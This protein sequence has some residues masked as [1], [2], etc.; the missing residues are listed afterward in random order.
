ME[1]EQ[2][3]YRALTAISDVAN[4]SRQS[5]LFFEN[6]KRVNAYIHSLSDE[7]GCDLLFNNLENQLCHAGDYVEIKKSL[8]YL[9]KH[10]D[11]ITILITQ[12]EEMGE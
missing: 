5:E 8:I 1:N 11:S 4:G 6:L 9:S 2:K 3:N 7:L 10:L 12:L